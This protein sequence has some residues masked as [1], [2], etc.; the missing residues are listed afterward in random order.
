M[1]KSEEV[2]TLTKATGALMLLSVEVDSKKLIIEH[3]FQS[4]IAL[5][6]HEDAAIAHNVKTT[7]RGCCEDRKLSVKIQRAIKTL[8]IDKVLG[9]LPTF[10]PVL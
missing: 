1:E 10:A 9:T 3:C 7:L 4:L 2:L 6:G 8:E 5:L